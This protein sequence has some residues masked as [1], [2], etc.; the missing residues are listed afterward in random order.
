VFAVG[1]KN[2]RIVVPAGICQQT[3]IE[4]AP[5]FLD[6]AGVRPFAQPR[7]WHQVRLA[8]DMCH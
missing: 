6:W 3:L 5:S 4:R 2:V 8:S 7:D 1:A